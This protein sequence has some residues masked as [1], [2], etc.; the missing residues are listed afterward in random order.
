MEQKRYSNE[1]FASLIHGSLPV[2]VDF[3]RDDCPPC[4]ALLPVLQQLEELMSGRLKIIKVN[5]HYHVDIV[6]KYT[7]RGVPHLK[8]FYRG[9]ELWTGRDV[10]RAAQLQQLIEEALE[11]YSR[12]TGESLQ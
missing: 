3:H 1:A 10:F 5:V 7:I 11:K 6:L 4:D 2:L 9:H 8:L 12:L